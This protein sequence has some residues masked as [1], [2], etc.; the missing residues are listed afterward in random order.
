MA[1]IKDVARKAGVS[2]STVSYALSGVRPVSEEKKQRIAEV[3]REL[4]FHP[5]TGAQRLASKRNKIITM[6]FSPEERSMGFSEISL[7]NEAIHTASQFGY[8]LILWSKPVTC[9][10]DIHHIVEETATDAVILTE[11]RNNDPR[12]PFLEQE[13][14]PYILF[15]RD[16]AV[17]QATFV[18][19]DFNITMYNALSYLA[20]YGHRNIAFINQSQSAYDHGYGPVIR[21]HAAFT[22][23]SATMR[24][25]GTAWFCAPDPRAGFDLT[26]QILADN[27]GTTAF[28]VM[29]DSILP[30]VIKAIEASGRR[31]P[32]DISLAAL[33]TSSRIAF[34]HIPRITTFEINLSRIMRLLVHLLIA[35]IEG[36]YFEIPERLIPCTLAEYDSTGRAPGQADLSVKEI[37][38]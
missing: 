3:M 10:D 29:N 20:K 6:L 21:M 30:G 1:T 11:I 4:D 24:N 19:V 38:P 9:R 36:T 32:D 28:L 27:P 17:P 26:S 31:I 16:T 7:V 33:V 18:D 12:I 37:H 25:P 2:I 35:K 14:I 5:N 23:I 34:M 22:D 15:G 8:T 13:K